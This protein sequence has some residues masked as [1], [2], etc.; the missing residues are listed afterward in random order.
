MQLL[1]AG[2]GGCVATLDRTGRELSGQQRLSREE[3]PDVVSGQR[4]HHEPAT[5]LEP[6]DALGSQ[7][8]Q[9]LADRGDADAEF[10]GDGLR[11]DEIPALELTGDD[12]VTDERLHLGTQLRTMPAVFP[13]SA[14]SLSVGSVTGLSYRL[15][16]CPL[17]HAV[18]A[19]TAP[20]PRRTGISERRSA[21]NG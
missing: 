9:A 12:Q 3:I 8:Q 21:S 20:G 18:P 11:P 5:W 6:H 10:L 19:G 16:M 2:N 13:G 17:P 4:D 1:H 15:I 7:C 14:Q